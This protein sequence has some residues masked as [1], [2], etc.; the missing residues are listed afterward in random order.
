MNSHPAQ[1]IWQLGY[2]QFKVQD[3][4]NFEAYLHDA[5]LTGLGSNTF[6]VGIVKDH[7]RAICEAR[8]TRPLQRILSDAI[9]QECTVLFET[10]DEKPSLPPE[11]KPIAQTRLSSL[12]RPPSTMR[13]P[14]P[15]R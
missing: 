5:V 15:V 1:K 11:I 6:V 2:S 13:K 4:G 10:L 3:S 12:N 7:V 9:G 14:E 8:I